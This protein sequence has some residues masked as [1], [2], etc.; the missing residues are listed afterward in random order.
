[1]ERRKLTG[2]RLPPRARRA[3]SGEISISSMSHPSESVPVCSHGE[4]HGTTFCVHC[5]YEARVAARKRRYRLAA[6]VGVLATGGGVLLAL[7]IGALTAVAPDARSFGR[8]VGTTVAARS[9]SPASRDRVAARKVPALEPS[10]R[11]GRRHLGDSIIAVRAGDSVIVTFDT[12]PLRTRFDWKFEGIVRATLPMVFGDEARAAL[13]SIP[14]G[15]LVRGGD[16][17]KEL[18]ARGIPLALGGG[19]ALRIWPMTRPGRDG[20][21]VVAYRASGSP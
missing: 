4:R 1:M 12:D 14:N 13:D 20:P 3:A 18:P 6:R 10:M 7:I 16:L 19:R 2:D 21:L 9:D 5:R 17:L 11:V 8:G 15:R